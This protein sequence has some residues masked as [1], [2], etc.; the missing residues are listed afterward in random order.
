MKRTLKEKY[1]YNKS[2]CSSSPFSR[3]YC[4]GVEVYLDYA[5]S[6]YCMQSNTK[7]YI[8]LQRQGAQHGNQ[9]SKGF[10]CGIRDAANERKGKKR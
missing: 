3:G 2:K 7:L 5:G 6:P 4:E 1:D 10:M 8:D 9:N